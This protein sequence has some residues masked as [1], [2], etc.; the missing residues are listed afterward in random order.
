[1]MITIKMDFHLSVI[2]N[3]NDNGKVGK[4]NI[5]LNGSMNFNVKKNNKNVAFAMSI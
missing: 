3:G 5:L 2:G 4:N 1:M